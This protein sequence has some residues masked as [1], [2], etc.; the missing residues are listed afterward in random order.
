[1]VSKRLIIN[2]IPNNAW[3]NAPSK[4][5]NKAEKNQAATSPVMRSLPI[6]QL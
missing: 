4:T 2:Y 1:M 5:I 3:Q 6:C